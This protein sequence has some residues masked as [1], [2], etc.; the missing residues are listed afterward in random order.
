MANNLT[1][2]M[3]DDNFNIST[4]T[5]VVYLNTTT[6][7]YPQVSG[8][9][10]YRFLIELTYNENIGGGVGNTKTISFTQQVSYQKVGNSYATFDLSQIYQ[11]IVT[12][13]I[14][15]ARLV[16]KSGGFS[17]EF[18]DNI[19]LLPSQG[20][21]SNNYFTPGLLE[22]SQGMG[23]FRGVANVMTLNFY[24]MYSDTEDGVPV[25][26]GT[27][28]VFKVFMFWGR[29][30]EEDGVI[31]DFTPYKLTGSTKKLLSS[32][33]NLSSSDTISNIDIGLNDYHTLAF[34]N[35]CEINLTAEPYK[36]AVEYYTSSGYILGTLEIENTNTNGGKYT[37]I[38]DT[39]FFYL[40]FGAGL[41]NLQ[42]LDTSDAGVTGTLPDS[43]GGGRSAIKSYSI[44]IKNSSDVARSIIYNFN[45]VDYCNQY[46]VSRLSY[47]N[48]FGAW[49][50]INLNKERTDELNVKKEYLTSPLI[51]QRSL[52]NLVSF[53]PT[54]IN[55]AYPL[56]NAKQG[57]TATSVSSEI[58][59]TMFTDYLDDAGVEQIKDM[60]MS[61]QIHLLD[62]E[63]AK[64]LILEKT[65]FRMKREKNRGLYQYELKFKFANPK[66]RATLG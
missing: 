27:S 25:K 41:E 34:L 43:V 49:E 30:Q 57:K 63:N 23:A 32:N 12:P 31:F 15:N 40:Y 59:T 37:T 8:K 5:N 26:Q 10:K 14:T 33:Y 22:D 13:Q 42:K 52:Q 50:Y 38:T 2:T 7:V 39:E 56:N 55:T 6:A 51:N 16:Q 3:N 62:G 54:A 21:G 44:V 17:Q 61:P 66:F 64:A 46:D 18:Y 53:D 35:L 20:A 19:H 65:S 11:T 45:V 9:Y 28:D 1:V 24:E 47:M 29:G 60:M 58:T 48:R 36:V 4:G